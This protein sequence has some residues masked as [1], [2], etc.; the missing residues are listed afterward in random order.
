MR[1]FDLGMALNYCSDW[2][3]VEA[4]REFFQNAIDAETVGNEMFWDYKDETLTIG[5]KN[6]ILE[7]NTLLL[8]QT[9]KQDNDDLIGQHG[10]G[11]KVA[12]VVLTRLGK[13]VKIYNNLKKEVWT[14]KV[15][16]S[17]RYNAQIVVFDIEKNFSFE[18]AKGDLVFEIQG[19]KQYEF[20][21]IVASNL[22]LQKNVNYIQAGKSRVLTG[23][24][25]AGKLYVGGLYVMT[26][27]YCY[28]GYDFE[29]SLV[30][31][32]RDR[33]FI[34]G[35]DLQFL[36]GKVLCQTNDV[37]LIEDT[38]YKWDGEYIRFY[39][40]TYFSNAE[41]IASL[42]NKTYAEFIAKNG[43][44]AIPVTETDD[45]N[46]LK[47]KGFNPVMVSANQ[48]FYITQSND[49]TGVAAEAFDVGEL[50]GDLETWFENWV[51]V[52]SDAYR[53][54]HDLIDEVVHYLRTL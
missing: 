54:G 52:D 33:G 4:V 42:Y 19:I 1:R 39:A 25:Q 24:N 51:D 40:S 37:Q 11:Y 43:E 29:P 7:T 8:G 13:T 28:Y 50:A 2:G 22:Y 32:D 49:Y 21:N 18:K 46:E 10:E 9:S 41:S 12:T 17:R 53:E 27:K 31:L 16:K 6:G 44:D 15:I 23:S 38:R 48:H 26:S 30:K 5:N 47:R 20:E 14:A 3:V 36:I 35:I 34:D 45:F